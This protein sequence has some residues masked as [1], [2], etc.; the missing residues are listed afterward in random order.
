MYFKPFLLLFFSVLFISCT[1]QEPRRPIKASSGSF[2][3]ESATRNKELYDEEKRYIESIIEKD[4][5][6]TYY[7]SQQGFWYVYEQRD[8]TKVAM[9]EFGDF[10][11]FTYD[12]RDFNGNVILSERDNGLQRYKIDQSHQELISGIREG[13]KLMH[14]GETV[15]FLFPSY[16]A[17]GY[18]GIERK[19]GTNV[20]VQSTVRLHSIEKT[21][22]E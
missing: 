7:S 6:R 15:T 20:P 13:L 4:S 10:V 8:T 14:E 22:D 11:E 18:Y 16:K 2:I 12:I 17:Y 21:D 19:L 3:K 1:G 5:A 9:P